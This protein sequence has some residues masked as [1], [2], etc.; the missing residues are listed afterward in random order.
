[1]IPAKCTDKKKKRL[2]HTLRYAY[3]HKIYTLI[4]ACTHKHKTLKFLPPILQLDSTIFCQK[5]RTRQLDV[6]L[7]GTTAQSRLRIEPSQRGRTQHMTFS[8]RYTQLTEQQDGVNLADVLLTYM[9]RSACSRTTELP[10][11]WTQRGS[12]R[13]PNTSQ[14]LSVSH[15]H[16]IS[17]MHKYTNRCTRKNTQRNTHI[18]QKINKQ[19]KV[20]LN[21]AL[22][23]QIEKG[24]WRREWKK[25]Q[26]IKR[27]REKGGGGGGCTLIPSTGLWITVVWGSWRKN[28]EKEKREKGRRE[29]SGWRD[30]W[31]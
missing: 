15:S 28:G 16:F 17:L 5:Y 29:E 31:R 12:I 6:W 22:P 13:Q 20:F 19:K 8:H 27:W 4:D 30:E 9:D 1:M 3:K 14:L 25:G 24:E 26:E 11:I 2:K 21:T 23:T 7:S 10:F 18:L